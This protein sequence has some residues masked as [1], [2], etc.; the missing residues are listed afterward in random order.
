MIEKILKE[1]KA[2]LDGRASLPVLRERMELLTAQIAALQAE[3]KR[4]QA[5]ID[6]SETSAE[7]DQLQLSRF[8]KP[9]PNGW[10]CSHY[11]SIDLVQTGDRK[12][13]GP[14]GKLGLRDAI[15]QCRPCGKTSFFELPTP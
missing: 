7:E 9:N 3:N 10:R 11:G 2:L 1:I 12:S 6:E 15:M 13:I 5:K 4:L 8:T 14:F